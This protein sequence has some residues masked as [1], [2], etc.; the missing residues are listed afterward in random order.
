M[1]ENTIMRSY[2]RKVKEVEDMKKLLEEKDKVL[3][4]AEQEKNRAD[5]KIK[6][7]MLLLKQKG[8]EVSEEDK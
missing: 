2:E 5:E 6:A 8:I 4:Q 1:K 7:L 3:K